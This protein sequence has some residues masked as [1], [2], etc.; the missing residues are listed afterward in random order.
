MPPQQPTDVSAPDTKS[1]IST[2]QSMTNDGAERGLR[3]EQSFPAELTAAELSLVRARITN[4]V[5]QGCSPNTIKNT[6]VGIREGS[7]LEGFVVSASVN[8]QCVTRDTVNKKAS[9]NFD[10][11]CKTV[12]ADLPL[13]GK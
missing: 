6:E 10:G 1:K 4:V 5:S 11:I 3:C 12:F 13:A 9:H 7:N 2:S 8:Y